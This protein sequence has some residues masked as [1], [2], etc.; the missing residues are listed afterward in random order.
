MINYIINID[1]ILE[2]FLVA[3]ALVFAIIIAIG[4]HE[5]AHG[6]AAYKCG[7][8][9]AKLSGRLTLNPFKHFDVF[10]ILMFLIVGI[11]WAKPVPINPGN[12]KNY[13]KGMFLVSIA[14][15]TVNLILTFLFA[16][17]LSLLLFIIGVCGGIVS[18]NFVYYLVYFFEQF[19]LVSIILNISLIAFNLL[20]IYPLDGFRIV[21]SLT[22]YDNPYCVFM[23]RY[24][25]YVLL[26]F[27]IIGTFV[28]YLDIVSR[29][30]DLI[31]T[32]ILKL[33]G[34]VF[35]LNFI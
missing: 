35:K 15:V 33:L 18:A 14:G 5:A 2:K 25:I 3:F 22:R 31:R 23:R 7:D 9:T 20:P 16:G 19:L 1:G 27:L 6:Y 29:F 26:G 8:M 17:L 34:I 21:E 12:F 24:G 28:P 4:F 10:G 13:K 32:A 30:I 11:G